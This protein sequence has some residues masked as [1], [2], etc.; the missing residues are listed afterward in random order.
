MGKP[1]VTGIAM[2][3][4]NALISKTPPRNYTIHLRTPF[5]PSTPFQKLHTL[6]VIKKC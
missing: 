2:L 1:I 5:N 6:E 3:L 4:Q